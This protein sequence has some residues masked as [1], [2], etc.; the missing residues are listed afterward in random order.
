[1]LQVDKDAENGRGLHVVSQMSARWG[2]RR[3]QAGKVVWCE[4]LVPQEIADAMRTA[5]GIEPPI[6]H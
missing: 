6:F 1:V 4:Q 5:M 2:A 3:S